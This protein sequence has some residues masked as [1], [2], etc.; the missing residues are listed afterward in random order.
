MFFCVRLLRCR[1]SFDSGDNYLENSKKSSGSVERAYT[2]LKEM[3]ASYEF[4]PDSRLNETELAK[5]LETSRTPL[6]EALNRLVAE[7]FLTFRSG[8]GFFC[9][10]LTS[11]EIMDLY[12]ARAAIECE[13]TRLAALRADPADV[14]ALERYLLGAD[15]AYQPGRSPVELVQLDEDF[16]LRLV[17]LSGNAEMVR[18]LGNIYGRIRY[19]RLIDLKTLSERTGPE[20]VTTEPHRRILQAVKRRDPD[21][22]QAEMRRHIERRLEAVT[23]NVRN[24]F[25]QLY[26][27]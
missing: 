17:A 9:R 23:E 10:S 1:R 15:D 7:G 3:A 13:A 8:Q 19:I 21:A 11:G 4:K 5:R 2:L 27:A 6:R 18:M 12:E 25:A 26:T 20:Y 16:H 22:A 14:E 24:A